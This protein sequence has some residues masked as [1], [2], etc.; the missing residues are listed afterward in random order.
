M[1]NKIDFFKETVMKLSQVFD[2]KIL[3]AV[4]FNHDD[5]REDNLLLIPK[6]Y[7]YDKLFELQPIIK[8]MHKKNIPAPYIMSKEYILSSLDAFPLEFLNMQTDYYNLITEE[9]VLN[10][11]NFDKKNIRLQIERELKS[12]YI[13]IKTA[14]ISI[15]NNHKEYEML[16]SDSI[17]SIKPTL[18]GILYLYGDTIPKVYE[19][20]LKKT[21]HS[22]HIDLSCMLDAFR[23]A[24]KELKLQKNDW[25][26]FY[27][28]YL[29]ELSDLILH[30]DKNTW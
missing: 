3:Q 5:P 13:L 2:N 11:L 19:E 4:I 9:D 22:I 16:A 17:L 8:T 30:I 10:T 26:K 21:E 23:I 1:N 6:D 14:L 24:H 15:N 29:K 25:V 7:E 12:K 20:I 28:D 27:K 18:K